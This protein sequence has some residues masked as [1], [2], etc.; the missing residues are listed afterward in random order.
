MVSGNGRG[1]NARI[2]VHRAAMMPARS[3]NAK[4]ETEDLDAAPVGMGAGAVGLDVAITVPFVIGVGPE[5]TI[6]VGV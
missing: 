1:W 6:A 2:E 5:L 3:T 4:A